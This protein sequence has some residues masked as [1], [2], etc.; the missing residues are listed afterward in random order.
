MVSCMR[1]KLFQ[2]GPTL[3]D[4]MDCSLP[5]SSVH[6]V[7]QARILEGLPCSPPGDLSSPGSKPMSLMSPALEMAGSLPLAP[8]EKPVVS[9]SKGKFSDRSVLYFLCIGF[10]LIMSIK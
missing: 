1:A 5:G 3:C 6:G 4:S 9:W 10:L 2:S 8:S 7:F